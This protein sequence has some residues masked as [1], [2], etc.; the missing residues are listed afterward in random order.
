M[1]RDAAR[2][3]GLT[4]DERN[5]FRS[6]VVRAIEV[7]HACDEGLAI[8]DGY[9]QPDR[10]AVAVEPRGRR[11]RLDRSAAGD[12]LASLRVA[13]PARSSPPASCPQ[14]RRTRPA[15]NV[16]CF[17]SLS[18]TLGW[19]TRARPGAA[20]QVIRKLPPCISSRDPLPRPHCRTDMTRPLL[21]GSGIPGGVTTASD[22]PLPSSGRRLGDAIDVVWCDGEPTRLLDAWADSDFAVVVDAVRTGAAPGTLHLWADGLPTTSGSSAGGATRPAS[23]TR[24]PSVALHRVPSALP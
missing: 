19:R 6:I 3:A 17:S 14:H 15:S 16:I 2:A 1:A 13:R 8:I 7:L 22:G 9:Q 23:R 12:A 21:V 24:W 18:T 11:P 4:A 20:E 5:P 10:P